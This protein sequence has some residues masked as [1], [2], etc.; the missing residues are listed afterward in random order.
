MGWLLFEPASYFVPASVLAPAC[1]NACTLLTFMVCTLASY[2]QQHECPHSWCAE[3]VNAKRAAAPKP[4][5]FSHVGRVRPPSSNTDG[6]GGRKERKQQQPRMPNGTSG[7]Q[8]A[9]GVKKMVSMS[10]LV[11]R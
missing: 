1:L 5:A 4:G 9:M 6:E 10:E 3:P 2:T 11:G 7:A 8:K